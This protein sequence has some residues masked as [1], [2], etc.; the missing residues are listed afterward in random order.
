MFLNKDT[1]I[2][3]MLMEALL[4]ASA[5]RVL[6]GLKPAVSGLCSFFLSFRFF[7]F[8]R[9]EVKFLSEVCE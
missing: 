5:S 7:T 3:V 1:K 6:A 4:A 9:S 2:S 8:L